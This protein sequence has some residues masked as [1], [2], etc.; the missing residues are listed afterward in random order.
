FETIRTDGWNK[1][2]AGQDSGRGALANQLGESRFLVFKS[3]DD[4]M[5]YQAKFGV[6]SAYDAMMGHIDGM[7][8]DT[9]LMEVLGPNPNA[10]VGWIKDTIQKS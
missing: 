1:R 9:A 3:A 5:A 10:T 7:S 2:T 8:R 4:W 6:G